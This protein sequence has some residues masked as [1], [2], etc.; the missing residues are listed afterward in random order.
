M[1][2]KILL[3][4]I[5]V[6]LGYGFW[7][8]PDFKEIAAGVAIF[9]FGMLSLEEG[10]KAFTGGILERILQRTTNR[11]WKS[12]SFGIVSTT[13]MQSSSL[14]SVITISFLSAG[15][16]GLASGI[17]II[18][19]ANLGTTTGAWLVAG[20]GLKV[21][22]SAYAM[23]MLV[24]GIILVFQKSK[25]LRGAGYILAGLGFLF[26]GIHHMKEGFEAFKDAID[27][28]AYAMPGLK[29]L[30][31]YTLLGAAATVV[32][33]SSHATLV[34]IITA[35]AAQQISYENALA[36]AIGANV[37]TTITAILG[38][39]SSNVQGRRLAGAHLIFNVTTG[40]V[41]I[42]FIQQFLLAVNGV[43]D[44]LGIAEDDYTMKL[45]V[46]H[47]L[48]N[49]AGIII[50]LPFT[51][52]LVSLLERLLKKRERKV[53][54]PLFLN[55]AAMEL[56]ESAMQAIRN[57]IGHLFENAHELIISALNLD[58]QK[59]RTSEDLKQL[60]ETTPEVKKI[61][62]DAIYERRIKTLYSAII[63]YISEVQ[64][65]ASEHFG[66]EL[67]QLR[68][69][70]RNIVEAVKDT[71]HLQKNLVRYTKS[72]NPKIQDQ[73]NNLRLQLAVVLSELAAAKDDEEDETSLLSLD[74]VQLMLEE[75]DVIANGDLDRLIRDN[76]ISAEMA[77][78][79]MN[80]SAYAY[81]VAGNLIDMARV[82]F[83]PMQ[84]ELRDVESELML[85]EEE[86]DEIISSGDSDNHN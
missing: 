7:V 6:V 30:L 22:I 65:T 41:A 50:M 19:G 49:L 42:I 17:G 72:T 29:G 5:F 44:R 9:L 25:S 38:A 12:L 18:F 28:A 43:S 11:L 53:E 26:L 83:G 13:V 46:F 73:Y 51:G 81:D 78:S 86:L 24:F 64:S 48:F 69:A 23:P 47:T 56:P 84:K 79:L 45:A 36:L 54:E 35:L 33:Q 16:I 31:V 58:P 8:S 4:T 85:S 70:S 15:L 39:M 75:S 80:D 55:E 67:Y 21:K 59:L 1:L 20:F 66:E 34:L 10:F 32:M 60:V 77:T 52:Q 76:A 14:V 63:A 74:S 37:G 40:L 57:E 2:R 82:L 68:Q 62:I 61:D 27:L 71:K 3:P